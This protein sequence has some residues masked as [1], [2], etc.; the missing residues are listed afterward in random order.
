VAE[1]IHV[2]CNENQLDALFLLSLFRQSTSTCF[3]HI[4]RPSS[5]GTLYIY[6]NWYVLYIYS[7]SPDDGLQI[8][9]KYIEDEWRN[10]LRI[11]IASRW[12]SITQMYR[13]A[14]STKHKNKEIPVLCVTPTVMLKPIN[15]SFEQKFYFVRAKICAFRLIPQAVIKL[16]KNYTNM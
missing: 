5:G 10:K 3:G 14:R 11:N 16:Y 12:F 1:E 2:P 4:C 6:N 7:I 9:P 13:D 15:I 8:C